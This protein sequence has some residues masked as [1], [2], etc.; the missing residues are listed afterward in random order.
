MKHIRVK[1]EVK[2]RRKDMNQKVNQKNQRKIRN[3]NLKIELFQK[4]VKKRKRRY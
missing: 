3:K 1:I 4:R 2:K